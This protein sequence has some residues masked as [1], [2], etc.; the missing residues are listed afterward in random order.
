MSRPLRM[1]S[2]R[3]LV[4]RGLG[5]VFILGAAGIAFSQR[6]PYQAAVRLFP[7]GE[8][9]AGLPVGGLD[10][11]Q[12]A[13]L[14]AAAYDR[15]VEAQYQG[16]TFQIQP[17]DAGLTLDVDG[18]LAEAGAQNSLTYWDYLW[19]REAPAGEIP[20]R[21]AVSE[22]KLRSFLQ[23]QVSPRYDQVAV[24]AMPIPGSSE[25][26]PGQ[27]GTA[28]DVDGALPLLKAA[29]LSPERQT[30][31]LAAHAV[32]PPPPS[33]DHLQ[34]MLRQLLSVGGYNG[35]AELYVTDLK[36]GKRLD[37]A[38]QDGKEI[39]P[40]V[41]FTAASTIKIA[42]MIS[43]FRRMPEPA[44]EDVMQLVRQM[45][46]ASDN[47]S[48]DR[49]VQ[50][51]LDPVRGPLEVT[52][53]LRSLGIEN[54][55]WAG[56]FYDGA[57]LL[58]SIQTPANQ[59]SDVNT[60]PDVYNQTTAADMGRLLED[61][62]R[63]SQ[64]GAGPLITAFPGEITQAK[65]QEMVALLKGNRIAVLLEGGLPEGTPIAHKHGWVQSPD[66]SLHVLADAGIV[67]SPGGD[68]IFTLY[69]DRPGLFDPANLLVA[70]L[71]QAVYNYF[72]LL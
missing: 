40:E 55:F 71:S 54:T 46:D 70:R 26:Y 60:Q 33:L 19:G 21:A 31:T 25:F 34:V 62:Y 36:T 43:I 17:A 30:V 18:M 59:R 3:S 32:A 53:D 15:P 1:S 8:K 6:V 69:L 29:F 41:A 50:S 9:V 22:E 45:I 52:Q 13:S 61:I 56:Y 44:P 66:G 24:P 27:P 58:E 20:L 68:Y 10:R 4:L 51:V 23:N 42:V 12:A 65:C 63:C 5:L 7:P 57:P 64:E 16:S 11:D 48:T 14:L 39:P 38:V 37:F 28:L 72:N 67:F 35:A 47:P 49:V 2:L